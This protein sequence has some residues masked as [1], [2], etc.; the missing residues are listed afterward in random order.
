MEK[1]IDEVMMQE[2]KGTWQAAPSHVKKEVVNLALS[3]S[4]CA[5]LPRTSTVL[6]LLFTF[7]LPTDQARSGARGYRDECVCN[8]CY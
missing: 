2:A 7:T 6:M 5:P 3:R 4:A 8:A 1:V